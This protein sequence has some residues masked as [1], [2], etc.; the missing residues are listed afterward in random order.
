MAAIALVLA[1]R[2][3]IALGLFLGNLRKYNWAMAAMMSAGILWMPW[4]IVIKH[5][6]TDIAGNYWITDSSIG[7][8]L[9]TIYKLFFIA[10]VPAQFSF[11][12]YAVTFAALTVGIIAVWKSSH[13]AR[14]TVAL[15]AFTP[16][17][18]AWIV[19]LVWQP[20]LL[21]RPLIGVSPF[22]YLVVCWVM[23][24]EKEL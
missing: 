24:P 10:A 11:A 22:L 2:E 7:A 9:I 3:N 23:Q 16:L 8:V 4:F 21:F 13:P 15:M 12:S 18:I 6:M 5:Q 19:S 1:V 14:V 17:F 20:V